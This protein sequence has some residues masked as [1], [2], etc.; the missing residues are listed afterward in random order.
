MVVFLK[1]M[2]A[3][4]SFYENLK[5]RGLDILNVFLKK[6]KDNLI[7]PTISEISKFVLNPKILI[8]R[9]A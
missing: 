9:Y 3:A 4:L 2:V 5:S 6:V 8:I 7:G 1:T